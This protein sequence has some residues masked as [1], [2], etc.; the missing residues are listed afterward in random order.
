MQLRPDLHQ[1]TLWNSQIQ[2][3]SG[4]GQ[5]RLRKGHGRNP[6]GVS[7]RP[8]GAGWSR[9]GLHLRAVHRRV[10]DGGKPNSKEVWQPINPTSI[11]PAILF[12]DRCLQLLKPG[13]RLLI[14]QP[15]ACCVTAARN[16]CVSTSWAR[17]TR[18]PGNFTEA[19]CGQGS[20]LVAGRHLQTLRH[21]GQDQYSLLAEATRSAG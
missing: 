9:W 14:I 10:G 18:K 6:G 17:R 21:R 12:L 2:E 19:R 4:K 5:E 15:T 16:T 8:Q 20:D 3:G 13:G 11:D 7:E 1:S